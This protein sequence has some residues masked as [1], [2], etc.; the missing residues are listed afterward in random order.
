MEM[1]LLRPDDL[2]YSAYGIFYHAIVAHRESCALATVSR[3]I[4]VCRQFFAEAL[5]RGL[6]SLNPA[7]RLRGFAVSAESKTL[8]LTRQQAK[9]LLE[10]IGTDTLL[11]LRDKAMLSLMIRTGLRRMDVI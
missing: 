2:H 9:E 11:D 7:V 1:S 4:S 5:D 8:G 10:K 6:I 3:K